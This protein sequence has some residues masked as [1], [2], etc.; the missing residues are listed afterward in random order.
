MKAC[1]VA[2]GNKTTSFGNVSFVDFGS[3]FNRGPAPKPEQHAQGR[4]DFIE[5]LYRAY[6]DELCAYLRKQFGSG[7]PEAEDLAQAAFLKVGAVEDYA[8]IRHPKAFLFRTA[9]NLGLNAKSRMNTAQ[10]F[11]DEAL[12][13][14]GEPIVEQNSPETVYSIRQHLSLIEE[15]M[16]DLSDK[17]RTILV[18]HRINGETYSE[19]AADTGWSKADISRQLSA[20]LETLQNAMRKADEKK[21]TGHGQNKTKQHRR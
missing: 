16:Q 17:Q 18:R 21:Q 20:T 11:I 3:V 9:L 7:P 14:A 1:P 15:A 5:S 4:G 19:I 2:A 13:E 6:W 12:A 8:S 10:S